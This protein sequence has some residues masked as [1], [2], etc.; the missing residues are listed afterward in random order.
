MFMKALF[1]DKNEITYEDVNTDNLNLMMEFGKI[2]IY[3]LNKVE[4]N[5]K[6]PNYTIALYMALLSLIWVLYAMCLVARINVF[7]ILIVVITHV[8]LYH[9]N[10]NNFAGKIVLAHDFLIYFLMF[11]P[12]IYTLHNYIH[13]S[14]TELL[15]IAEI[16]LFAEG[17]MILLF[18]A[19]NNNL[20]E[21]YSSLKGRVQG[22]KNFL[23][24]A[25]KD[26]L[27]LL[28]EDN[29]YY[30]YDILPYTM[31]LNISDVWVDKF[32]CINIVIPEVDWYIGDDIDNTRF[33]VEIV[34][35]PGFGSTPERDTDIWDIS[36]SS[37]SHGSGG[38][39]GGFSGGGSGGG[40]G[41]S[42]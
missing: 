27:E 37:S 15:C 42:W 8:M 10:T 29:P 12:F 26:E 41:R 40:G 17:I 1:K 3:A 11:V 16:I 30:F 20:N 32:K 7:T 31:A 36:D 34:T 4:N 38:S 28:V 22:F 5:Y 13:I 9:R 23:I 33:K 2:N 19:V 25:R 18:A 35:T 24:A 6:K 39:N 21:E 14:V